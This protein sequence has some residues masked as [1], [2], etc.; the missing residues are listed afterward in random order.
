MNPKAMGNKIKPS[1][2][3]TTTNV[4][5]VGNEKDYTTKQQ[6]ENNP[7]WGEESIIAQ[8]FHIIKTNQHPRFENLPMSQNDQHYYVNTPDNLIMLN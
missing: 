3:Y 6:V 7:Q 4:S 5:N 1:K 2:V 8:L